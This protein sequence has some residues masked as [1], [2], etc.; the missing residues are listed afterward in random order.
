M[1]VNKVKVLRNQVEVNNPLGLLC[2]LTG[3][4]I[5]YYLKH[6]LGLMV[7]RV[8]FFPSLV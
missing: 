3:A 2:M 1:Y 5:C 6:T 4:D 7:K 8:V